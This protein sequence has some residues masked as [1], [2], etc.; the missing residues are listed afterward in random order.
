MAARAQSAAVRI[1]TLEE[2]ERELIRLVCLGLRDAQLARRL[3]LDDSAVSRHLHAIY[4]KL[5]LSNRLDLV[6]YAYH[7]GLAELPE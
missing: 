3:H 5:G 7:Y 1:K 2:V 6:I 4:R